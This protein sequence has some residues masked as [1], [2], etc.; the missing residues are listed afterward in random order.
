M[1]DP[2]RHPIDPLLDAEL[3]GLGL[4]SLAAAG[5]AG[6]STEGLRE[7]LRQLTNRM[8]GAKAVALRQQPIP[9]AYRVFFRH[10]GV[11][12]DITRTPIERAV[13][14]RMFHGAF[15]SV[16]RLADALLMALVETGVPVWA[17]DAAAVV[18]GLHLRMAAPEDAH[19]PAG[20]IAVA[21][22][23]GALAEL[24]GPIAPAA[25]AGRDTGGLLLF[26]VAVKGVP[27][28]CVEEALFLAA[29]ALDG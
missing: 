28:L 19:V 1:D 20:R 17:L 13:L 25:R 23:D 15:A 7:Q 3:P 4:W 9:Q 21:D 26:S 11:D 8:G 10:T 6:P 12:P 22:A 29:E 5:P 18:P 2:V 16:D 14:D 24:F 27:A